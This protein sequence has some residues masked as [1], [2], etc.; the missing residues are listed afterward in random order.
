V[1]IAGNRLTRAP[2]LQFALTSRYEW[3]VGNDT[4]AVQAGARHQGSEYFLETQQQSPTFQGSGW[5]EYDAR[6]SLAGPGDHWKVSLFGRN[7]FDNR[8]F[9]QITA[10]FGLPN[11][12]VNDP[13]TIGV[14]L[15]VKY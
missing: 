5:T 3:S 6:A 10:F 1:N 7:L 9:T 13:R 11:G 8:H 12:A 15:A 2:E 4:A 14:E